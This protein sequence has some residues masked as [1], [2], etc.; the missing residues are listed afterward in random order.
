MPRAI[1]IK[2]L[3]FDTICG[4]VATHRIRDSVGNDE[5]TIFK[6]CD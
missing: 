6:K 1:S 5:L 3:S 4:T 2:Y